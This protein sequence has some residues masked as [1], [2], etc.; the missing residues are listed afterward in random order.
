M[1]SEFLK[2]GIEINETQERQLCK[3]YNLLFQWNQKINLTAITEY[4]MVVR[5]HFI[6]S[7]LLI[8][9][10]EYQK[11]A[12]NDV[13]DIGTGAGF[14][15]MVLAI[16][17]PENA[18]TL[19]DSVGKRIEFLNLVKEE[20]QLDNVQTFHGRAEDFGQ[21]PEFRNSFDFVVSRAVAELPL[22]L[23]YCIPFVKVDGYFVSYKGPKYEEEVI[24]S[25]HALSELN[26]ELEKAEKFITME[27]EERYLLFLRKMS[28]TNSKYPRRAG[29]PKKK[30]L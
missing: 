1:K 19:I 7:A 12:F 10:E 17:C 13:L 5:K 3:Y 26:A 25:S 20:L 28:L 14:P 23:E 27:N 30:P 18:F 4:D 9:C 15:G 24:R 21:N 22:L 11:R 8:K 6:D 16:L 2:Y 29:K